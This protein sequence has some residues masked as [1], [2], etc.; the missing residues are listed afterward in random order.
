M[1]LNI[2]VLV[3]SVPD[4]KS[5]VNISPEGKLDLRNIKYVV[6]P[7]DKYAVEAALQLREKY[8]GRV[9]G[10]S[11]GLPGLADVYREVL[12]MGV[13]E[14]IYISD[15][16]A[17][18][19][20][21][22]QTSY[23]ISNGLGKIREKYGE[24]NLILSGVE[25]SDTNSGQVPIQLGELLDIPSIFY[26]DRILEV[27]RDSVIVK[28][29]IED[30]YMIIEAKIPA[31]LAIADTSYEPRI[32][33]LRDVI[34]ARRKSIISWS[35]NEIMREK[36]FEAGVRLAY[37]KPVEIKRKRKII[38]EED[39]DKALDKFFEELRRDNVSLGG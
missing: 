27:K 39:V 33:S 31:I 23:I 9:I 5:P 17:R 1:S 4:P 7:G 24:I 25:A 36:L 19:Y 35:L 38:F 16:L 14:F 28:R 20:D 32:P 15:P 11:L 29:I 2:V 26:V 34:S 13:D 12:A 22:L 3:K 21:T 18:D 37:V 8:G 10:L 30:G 6:N